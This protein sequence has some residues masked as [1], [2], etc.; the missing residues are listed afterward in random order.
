M[1]VVSAEQKS[2]SVGLPTCPSRR[3]IQ[4]A[5]KNGKCHR[6]YDFMVC[7]LEIVDNIE[8]VKYAVLFVKLDF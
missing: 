4:D 6:L 8:G 3:C 7:G 1:K 5:P 2:K